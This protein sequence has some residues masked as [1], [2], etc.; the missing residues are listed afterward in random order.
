MWCLNRQD[1]TEGLPGSPAATEFWFI[2]KWKKR[3]FS[4]KLMTAFGRFLPVLTG[5][6]GSI[7]T[8]LHRQ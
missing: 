8:R 6:I 7:A 1:A 3:G 2:L 5:C 4:I